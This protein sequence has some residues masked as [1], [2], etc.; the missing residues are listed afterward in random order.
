[1]SIKISI[2]GVEEREWDIME[3]IVGKPLLISWNSDT[4]FCVAFVVSSLECILAT[5]CYT[6]RK[7]VTAV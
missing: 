2:G 6:A 7:I 1:M 5:D 4:W 3:V